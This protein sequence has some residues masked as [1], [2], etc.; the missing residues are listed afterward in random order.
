[1]LPYCSFYSPTTVTC[2]R[3]ALAASG[4]DVHTCGDIKWVVTC[5]IPEN[6]AYATWCCSGFHAIFFGK[7]Y[8]WNI[9]CDSTQR[10]ITNLTLAVGFGFK[11]SQGFHFTKGKDRPAN[12]HLSTIKSSAEVANSNTE[13]DY[14]L[15]AAPLAA[16]FL[17][18]SWS[19]SVVLKNDRKAIFWTKGFYD[20]RCGIYGIYF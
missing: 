4:P 8:V 18:A 12:C 9:L 3:S 16:C 14:P 1:M 6:A 2:A 7:K 19:P 13:L 10:S 15:R 5:Y 20:H 17:S 11:S